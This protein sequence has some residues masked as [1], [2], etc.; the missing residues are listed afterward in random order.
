MKYY[1]L[2]YD[3]ENDDFYI[4]CDE[5]CIG[6]LDEY[7]VKKGI[8][9]EKWQ[10]VSFKYDS[11]EGNVLSDYAANSLTW[12][13]IS[14]KCYQSIQKIIADN[15]V[16][17]LPVQLIDRSEIQRPINYYVSNVVD[18]VE[19]AIDME[20]SKYT[21]F[22]SGDNKVVSFLKYVLRKEVIKGHHIFKLKEAPFSVFVSEQIRASIIQNGM[23]GFDFL[24]IAVN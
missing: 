10:N 2:L 18:M 5:P 3:Y 19:D 17:F 8:P 24:E 15:G 16:Q 14:K 20:K 1:K 22:G 9:L 4:N 21:M 23:T 6:D 12:L 7:C 13:V 11:R